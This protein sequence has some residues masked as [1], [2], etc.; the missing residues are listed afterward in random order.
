VA[1]SGT[2]NSSD[3]DLPEKLCAEHIASL[4]NLKWQLAETCG[5]ASLRGISLSSTML[6]LVTVAPI[7]FGRFSFQC[8]HSLF[9]ISINL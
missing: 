2:Y 7:Q 5:I 6:D 1:F 9:Y 8:Y 4:V 3:V